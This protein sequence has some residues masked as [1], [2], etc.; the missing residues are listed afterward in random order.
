[1]IIE[2][3]STEIL[4]VEDEVLIREKTAEQLRT[5]GFNVVTAE[6]GKVALDIFKERLNSNKPIKVVVTD[7]K[8]PNVN[9][10]ELIKEISKL[11]M[12]TAFIVCS[13]YEQLKDELEKFPCIRRIH[14]K[15]LEIRNIIQD[16]ITIFTN[17][18]WELIETKTLKETVIH[19]QAYEAI[20]QILLKII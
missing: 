19:R 12:Q 16:L 18:E 15:P 20:Q 6:D 1:M 3:T 11:Q 14:I 4:L 13:A 7:M 17:R 8:M 5:I 9:G 2:T 10:I